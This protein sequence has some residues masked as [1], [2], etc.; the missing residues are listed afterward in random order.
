MIDVKASVKKEQARAPVVAKRS[1]TKKKNLK[2]EFDIILSVLFPFL[3]T[4]EQQNFSLVNHTVKEWMEEACRVHLRRN[5]ITDHELKRF[6]SFAKKENKSFLTQKLMF[7]RYKDL[8]I[9]GKK[10]RNVKSFNKASMTVL[11]FYLY[12]NNQ[13]ALQHLMHLCKDFDAS[14][15][16]IIRRLWL[17]V[18]MHDCKY[19]T[20]IN[21]EQSRR[22]ED[23]GIMSHTSVKYNKKRNIVSIQNMTRSLPKR[24]KT[25]VTRYSPSVD[26]K[27]L[28]DEE[29]EEGEIDL[30]NEE[31][32]EERSSD[33]DSEGS[34][35]DFIVDDEESSDEEGS[36]S[37]ENDSGNEERSLSD[38]ETECSSEYSVYSDDENE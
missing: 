25:R 31:G 28:D 11:I 4:K 15:A 29:G 5:H 6:F 22:S 32:I 36:S 27:L 9:N 17:R 21:T 34:L 13:R 7:D 8:R 24:Q 19:K 38:N 35:R 3:G 26:G 1:P 12:N 2:W 37:E 23:E 33:S 16:K 20:G 14:V 30:E 10:R 18:Q